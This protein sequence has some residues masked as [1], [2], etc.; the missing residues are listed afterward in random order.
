MLWFAYGLCFEILIIYGASWGLYRFGVHN[1][2]VWCFQE[3]GGAMPKY[4]SWLHPLF[5]IIKQNRALHMDIWTGTAW[6]KL[7]SSLLPFE[8]NHPW[9]TCYNVLGTPRRK[10]NKSRDVPRLL[11]IIC[12]DIPRL[13]IY[14]CRAVPRRISG[15]GVNTCH[16]RTLSFLCFN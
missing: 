5:F 14:I 7:V 6:L 3:E 11:V 15:R 1:M 9:K 13:W 4:N 16:F 10:E 2:T 8:I 12:R